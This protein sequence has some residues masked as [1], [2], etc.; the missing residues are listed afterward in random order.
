MTLKQVVL[1]V[2]SFS[3]L[4]VVSISLI[5]SWNEPQVASR[6]QLYQTDLLLQ[7]TEWEGS[8]FP[9]ED[10]NQLRS[11]LLG[12]TPLKTAVDQYEKVQKEAQT[13]IDRLNARLDRGLATVDQGDPNL[14]KL[15]TTLAQQQQLLGQLSL[16]LGILRSQQDDTATAYQLWQE[17]QTSEVASQPLAQTAQTLIDLYE[18][19]VEVSTQPVIFPNTRIILESN[20]DG[21]FRNR[22][23]EKFYEVDGQDAARLDLL[24]AEH[25]TA[26][27]TLVKLMVIGVLPG[28]AAVLGTV[29]LI[30]LLIQWRLRGY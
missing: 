18:S 22:A 11:V 25:S 8:G 27:A 15:Q 2:I 7:A 12:K 1:G 21:W 6:L 3:V 9:P 30:A 16:R 13:S 29:L 17:L 28:V 24:K 19:S 23:L 14:G 20:L 10:V 26:E 5:T 4:L